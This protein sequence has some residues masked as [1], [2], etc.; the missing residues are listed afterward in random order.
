MKHFSSYLSECLWS[1]FR[2][3]T[4]CEELSRINMRGTSMK[5][6]YGVMW[7]IKYLSSPAEDVRTPDP[8]DKVTNARLRDRQPRPQRIFSL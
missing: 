8:F 4:C 6:S 3:V 2:V 5:W 1:L 7:Q